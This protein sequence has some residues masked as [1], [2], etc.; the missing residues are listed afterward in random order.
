MCVFPHHRHT[1]KSGT[2][3]S[4]YA[5]FP[6]L[7]SQLAGF[8]FFFSPANKKQTNKKDIKVLHLTQAELP[9]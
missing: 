7:Q 6:A 2:A 3:F 1:F 5:V 4:F 8:L 9:Q